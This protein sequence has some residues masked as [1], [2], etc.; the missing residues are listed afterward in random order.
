MSKEKLSTDFERRRKYHISVLLDE[1]DEVSRILEYMRGFENSLEYM[2]ES[3]DKK[4]NFWVR[5]DGLCSRR[6]EL[7]K[8]L[9]E[10]MLSENIPF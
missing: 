7:A 2:A 5:F 1:L 3:K 8:E 9:S 10:E 6:S 4:G